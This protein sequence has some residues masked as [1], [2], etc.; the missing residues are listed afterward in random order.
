VATRSH[1]WI[2]W[3][4]DP[5]YVASSDDP[6]SD[7]LAASRRFA[8][9][10]PGGGGAQLRLASCDAVWQ[11]CRVARLAVEDARPPKALLRLLNPIMAAL[12]R[13][14]WHRLAS[15]NFI[16]L[17]VTGRKSGRTYTLPVTR[18]EQPDGTLVISAAGAWRHN[19]RA[20]T[21]V[22][23]TLDGRERTAHVTPVE[24]PVR[25]AE[26]FKG[27][28][29][30]SSARDVGVKVN[31]DRSPTPDEIRPVLAHRVIAYLNFAD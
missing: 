16:L 27:L 22:R 2:Y 28:L 15:K 12:L 21:D 19:L 5:K 6:D 7:T 13:S 31:L 10:S 17:T 26:V 11:R 30:N 14:R 4:E 29:D 1:P 9:S 8:N 23:V 18:H 20:G 3:H 25:A 24:D